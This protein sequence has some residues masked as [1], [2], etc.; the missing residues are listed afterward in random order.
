MVAQIGSKGALTRQLALQECIRGR[1]IE[2]A[3]MPGTDVESSQE[4]LLGA[5]RAPGLLTKRRQTFVFVAGLLL[6]CAAISFW[7]YPRITT[8][9]NADSYIELTEEVNVEEVN[10]DEDCAKLPHIKVDSV[11]SNNLGKQGPNKNAEEGIVYKATPNF[12]HR[13]KDLQIHLHSI[14]SF[15]VAENDKESYDKNYRPAWMTGEFSNGLNG[16]FVCVN[17]KPGNSVKLRL[18]VYDADIKKNLPLSQGVVSFFDFDTGPNS[19]EY[20]KIPQLKHY[21]LTNETK[22]NFRPEG[23]LRVFSGSEQGN[24]KDNPSDPELLTPEQ[25]DK[26]VTIEIDDGRTYFDFEVG[27]TPGTSAGRVFLFIFRPI[28]LCAKIKMPDG[29]IISSHNGTAPITIVK[30]GAGKELPSACLLFA[31]LTI[32]QSFM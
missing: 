12:G 18:S 10:L 11:I 25:E 4:E 16:K 6:M 14:S 3:V 13:D 23:N 29:R 8:K 9:I 22:V 15:D 7:Q 2:S 30:G 24:G 21:Y 1:E 19:I 26:A 32:I 27:A 28:L 31:C 20:V 5:S 17:I